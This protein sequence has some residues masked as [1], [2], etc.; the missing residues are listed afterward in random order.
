LLVAG[1]PLPLR[2]DVPSEAALTAQRMETLR[3]L[4]AFLAAMPKGGDLHDHAD[5][6]V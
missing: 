5:G 3:S 1:A 6:A 4:V 2:A